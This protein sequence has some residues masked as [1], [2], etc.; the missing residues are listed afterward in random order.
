MGNQ[1]LF[2]NTCRCPVTQSLVNNVCVTTD[3]CASSPCKNH[4]KCHYSNDKVTCICTLPYYGSLCEKTVEEKHYCPEG[5]P[6]PH[7]LKCDGKKHCSDGSDE[8]DCLHSCPGEQIRVNNNC[9]CPG[10]QI[11]VNNSCNCSQNQVLINGTCGCP[12]TLTLINNV[13]A[14]PGDQTMVKNTCT[15]PRNQILVN[16]TCQ[17]KSGK[18]N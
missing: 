4:G 10:N 11:L 13:C 8:K 15:C 5:Y 1:T 16:G 7:F 17:S 12:G 6:I 14:C 18:I 3:L 2:D 9:A